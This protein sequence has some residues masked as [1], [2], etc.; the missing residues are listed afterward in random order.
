MKGERVVWITDYALIP[1]KRIAPLFPADGCAAAMA[2]ADDHILGQHEQC[3]FDGVEE[4]A[5]I[6]SGKIATADGPREKRVAAEAVIANHYRASAGGMAGNKKHIHFEASDL[7]PAGRERKIHTD[8][9]DHLIG[10]PG[11]A[12]DSALALSEHAT[13]REQGAYADA[14]AT[15]TTMAEGVRRPYRFHG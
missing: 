1:E 2:G 4:E 7:L 13:H 15:Q 8:T 10:L 6:P 3:G 14:D 5:A 12:A 9:M 11:G